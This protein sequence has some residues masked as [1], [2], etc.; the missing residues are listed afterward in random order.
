MKTLQKTDLFALGRGAATYK[1]AFSDLNQ[2]VPIGATPPASPSV[3][4]LW[5]SSDKG[6]LYTFDGTVWI[7]GR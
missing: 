7:G 4:T 2:M 3:G 5:Y 1:V 6:V